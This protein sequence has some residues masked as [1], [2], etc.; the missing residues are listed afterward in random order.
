[1]TRIIFFVLLPLLAACASPGLDFV[2]R[3]PVKVVVDGSDFSVWHDRVH[4][5]AIRTNVERRRG[6]MK[7]GHRAIELATGCAIR[8]GTFQGDGALFEAGLTCPSAPD[9]SK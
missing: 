9:L 1:M 6:V 8:P 2:G 3:A 5:Q 4:A 7:R